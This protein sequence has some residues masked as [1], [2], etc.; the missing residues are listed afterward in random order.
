MNIK[1]LKSIS[2]DYDFFYDDQLYVGF[3]AIIEELEEIVWYV[4]KMD[5]FDKQKIMNYAS[6]HKN[7]NN[8]AML[9]Q[10]I[11]LVFSYIA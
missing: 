9:P 7:F 10:D 4:D 11:E 5:F 3:G 1:R 2:L 6:H 8:M